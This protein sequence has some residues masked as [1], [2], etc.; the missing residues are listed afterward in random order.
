[1]YKKGFTLIELL[2]VIAIIGILSSVVLASLNSA[3][4]KGSDA[5]VKAQ[6]SQVRAEAELSYD[7]NSY[8]Y[9][10]A[11]E[12]AADLL[13]GAVDAGGGASACQDSTTAWAASVPLKSDSAIYFCVD[14]TGTAA[15]TSAAVSTTVCP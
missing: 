3:R 2:V 15:T 14:S 8:S 6:L 7:E 12:D 11:C 10:N 13:A 5:A 4:S 9:I 1:M